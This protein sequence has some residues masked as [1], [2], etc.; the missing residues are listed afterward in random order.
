MTKDAV[1][2]WSDQAVFGW[3]DF[4]SAVAPKLGEI[5]ELFDKNEKGKA[6]I[7]KLIA[8]LRGARDQVSLPRLAYLLARGFEDE[9][10]GAD[11]SSM[12]LYAWATDARERAALVTALEWYVYSI[13]EK[14]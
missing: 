11:E 10:D 1:A 8:L 7:Y 2:L 14:G 9:G 4:E 12:R 13:R 6:L 3:D 5:R